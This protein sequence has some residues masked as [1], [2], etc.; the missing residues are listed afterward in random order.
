MTDERTRLLGPSNEAVKRRGY[1]LSSLIF[2]VP[3]INVYI[4]YKLDP[5]LYQLRLVSVIYSLFCVSIAILGVYGVITKSSQALKTSIVLLIIENALSIIVALVVLY[6]YYKGIK[7]LRNEDILLSS[8]LKKIHN[9]LVF[10][11]SLYVISR[12]FVFIPAAHII[13]LEARCEAAQKT[14]QEQ[15][16]EKFTIDVKDNEF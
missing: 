7:A 13:E 10:S 5:Q 15:D 9:A 1:A 12:C 11:L 14:V 16:E 4:L 8:Y 2:T 6:M 3:L